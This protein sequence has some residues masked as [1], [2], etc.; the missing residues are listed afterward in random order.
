MDTAQSKRA[1]AGKKQ[2]SP[3]VAAALQTTLTDPVRSVRLAAARTLRAT[4]DLHSPAG[5]EFQQALDVAAA[6]PTG[7]FKA[8]RFLL[9]RGRVTA[10]LP[11]LEQAA[12][13]DPISPPYQCV[14]AQ[15]LDQ[16]GQ[17]ARAL[18]ILTRET[19]AVPD[20]PQTAYVLAAILARHGRNEAARTAANRALAIQHDFRP[21]LDL[22]RTL[23][24]TPPARPGP[25]P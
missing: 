6:Q 23:P 2:V 1:D 16:L 10:A 15:V 17:T 5:R 3:E 7:Q 8:A 20:D 24:A 4:L 9:A 22:L 11:H 19:A 14:R 12:A 21:A 25:H 13:G 18:D